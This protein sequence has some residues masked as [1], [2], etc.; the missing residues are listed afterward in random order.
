MIKD[1]KI[2][3]YG[4]DKLSKSRILLLKSK[5][6]KEY[7]KDLASLRKKYNLKLENTFYEWN[8]FRAYVQIVET[9]DNVSHILLTWK[10]GEMLS[11]LVHESV[12]IVH[13]IFEPRGIKYSYDNDEVLTYYLESIFNLL[14][15]YLFKPEKPI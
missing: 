5:D 7:F 4:E 9:E 3:L 1:F 2:P 13:F 6:E 14:Y 12:H 11:T 10:T 8:E 15:P